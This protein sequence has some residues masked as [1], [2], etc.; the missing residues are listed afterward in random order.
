M[1]VAVGTSRAA[2]VDQC[3]PRVALARTATGQGEEMKEGPGE[4]IDRRGVGR[5]KQT[6]YNSFE[7]LSQR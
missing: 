2:R 5:E 7:L 3:R 1:T 4:S 6:T